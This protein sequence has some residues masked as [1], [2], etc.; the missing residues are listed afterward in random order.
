M[1]TTV[2]MVFKDAIV[3][4]ASSA[5]FSSMSLQLGR[6]VLVVALLP[7]GL[8]GFQAGLAEVPR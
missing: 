6:S 8:H 4:L 5:D 2:L 7:S 1:S 3:P